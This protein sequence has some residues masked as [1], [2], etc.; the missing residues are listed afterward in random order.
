MKTTSFIAILIT[1]ATVGIARAEETPPPDKPKS[2]VVAHVNKDD[3]TR[4]ELDQAMKTASQRMGGMAMSEEQRGELQKQVLD[5]LVS[6]CLLLQKARDLKIDDLDAKVTERIAK[7]KEQFPDDKAFQEAIKSAGFDEAKLKVKVTEGV[8]I[9]N[10]I[11]RE[12]RSKIKVPDEEIQKF[13]DEHPEYFSTPAQVRAS[14]IL[15]TCPA[16]ADDQTK[17]EKKAKID[18]ARE[19]VEKGE[20]FA[21]VANEMSDCPSKVRGGDLDFFSKG[22]MVK[23]FEEVAFSMKSNEVSQVVATQFGYHI[24][25]QTGS[26]PATVT[27]LADEKEK[28]Q[29]HLSSQKT[30]DAVGA[31]VE[32]LR[33]DAKIEILLK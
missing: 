9:E 30:Q 1:V 26:K 28:I 13:Y 33:K 32:G 18:A 27:P 7:I 5:N 25:K 31:Y 21:K 17:A 24:I 4:E 15:V 12:V 8:R 10:L 3:I 20:D 14:H 29:Q 2:E 16:D 19:R 22:H 23:P 6:E 11:E